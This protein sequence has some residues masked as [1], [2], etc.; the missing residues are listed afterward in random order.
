MPTQAPSLQVYESSRHFPYALHG[1]P[2]KAPVLNRYFYAA[3]AE[4]TCAD[5]DL[6]D[7]MPKETVHFCHQ[8]NPTYSDAL[9][10][11]HDLRYSRMANLVY[12]RAVTPHGSK[13]QKDG[14]AV[15]R[16]AR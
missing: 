8:I 7:G 4:Q 9:L 10:D 3:P 1:K 2:F 14:K 6:D 15:P 11:K 16:T 5:C 12:A 13:E